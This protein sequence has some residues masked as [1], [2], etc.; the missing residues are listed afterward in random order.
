MWA[1][2]LQKQ[3]NKPW[4]K[5]CDTTMTDR[6]MALCEDEYWLCDR[7]QKEYE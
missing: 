1:P 6:E 3:S 5:E 2:R 4:C 7:C